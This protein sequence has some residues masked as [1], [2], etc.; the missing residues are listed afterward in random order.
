MGSPWSN[1]LGSSL[2]SIRPPRRNQGWTPFTP[3][4]KLP[5][6]VIE[7]TFVLLKGIGDKTERRWWEAGLLDWSAF[8]RQA[9]IQGLSPTRKRWYDLELERATVALTARDN[10]HFAE[11]LRPR[12]HW[13]M[14][15]L[16]RERAVFLDIETTGG[17]PEVGSV[18][19]VGLYTGDTCVQLIEGID[20]TTSRLNEVL[21][22]AP[23]VVTFFGSVFDIPFLKRVFPDLRTP[24]L[25]IDLCFAARRLGMT[26]GLKRVESRLGLSRAADLV[27]L[28]GWDAVHLWQAWQQGHPPALDRLL[29]YNKADTVHL[30]PL[31]DHLYAELARLYG[32]PTCER[33]AI[34]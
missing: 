23:L 1:R 9:T 29:R 25:H 5:D 15:P 27:G 34:H 13:R 11:C 16:F 28:D 24:S 22:D 20:L 8:L 26:G 7:S 21:A 19:V 14:L 12:D 18:T 3:S 30:A 17:E 2:D 6:T 31:A 33:A 32:P 10:H 4:V